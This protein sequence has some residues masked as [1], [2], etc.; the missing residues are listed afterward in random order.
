MRGSGTEKISSS[1]VDTDSDPEFLV[2]PSVQAAEDTFSPQ[3]RTSS[4]SK[5]V[6]FRLSSMSVGNFALLNP[7]P[8]PGT[9]LNPDTDADPQHWLAVFMTPW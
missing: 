3:K 7:D 8:D 5:N 9:P 2:N 6:I 1:V 4:T